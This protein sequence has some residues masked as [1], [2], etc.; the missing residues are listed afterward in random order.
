MKT[1]AFL[2]IVFVTIT[3]ANAQGCLPYGI[4]FTTQQQIDNF[5]TNYPGCTEIEGYVIISG[6]DIT[7]LDGLSVLTSIGSGLSIHTNALTSFTGL[8]NLTSIGGDLGIEENYA[9]TSI[10][11]LEGLTSIGGRLEVSY[12]YHL[13]S[14]TGLEGL[15]SIGGSLTIAMNQQMNTLIGLEGLTTIGGSFYIGDSYSLTSLTGLEGLTAI[16]NDLWIL[17]NI[18][19]VTLIGIDNLASIGGDLS[20]AD[21]NSLSTC[22]VESIC[23]YLTSPNSE[24]HINDNNSGC[25]S[26]DEVQETCPNGVEEFKYNKEEIFITPNPSNDDI[27][28]SSPVINGNTILSIFTFSG[29]KVI[30]TQLIYKETQIDISALPQGIYFVRV[31][32]ENEVMVGKFVKE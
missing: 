24:I 19:L 21:N 14:L 26:V 2:L 22:D 10:I 20:I 15:T 12:N 28:I 29:K 31:Q 16:G 1:L 30:E 32:D 3:S 4:T 17:S 7:N 5:Q 11:G 18:N 8:N 25:N 27:T 13:T 9:L 6:N 23:N